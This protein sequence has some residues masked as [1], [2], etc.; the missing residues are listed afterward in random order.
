MADTKNN[1]AR[2]RR[3][4][5]DDGTQPPTAKKRRTGEQRLS[6]QP[7]LSAPDSRASRSR[8]KATE[9]PSNNA[10]RTQIMRE[11]LLQGHPPDENKSPSPPSPVAKV[12]AATLLALV[13]L[14]V[15]GEAES[16]RIEK[17]GFVDKERWLSITKRGHVYDQELRAIPELPV[18]PRIADF[19]KFLNATTHL[20]FSDATA[21]TSSDARGQ[22]Q[23]YAKLKYLSPNHL[24]GK[25]KIGGLWKAMTLDGAIHDVYRSGFKNKAASIAR[26]SPNKWV[27]IPPGKARAIQTDQRHQQVF[28][29]GATTVTPLGVFISA[30]R[31]TPSV[32][33]RQGRSN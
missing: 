15:E 12:H 8:E 27:E 9:V 13:E 10:E 16:N 6:L 22:Q 33:S 24:T 29:T 18:P 7:A 26:A 11:Y 17:R 31:L 23:Q 2:A 25:G 30:L 14:Y 21:S 28:S 4:H 32:S 3:P 5:A 1:A 19:L 20:D